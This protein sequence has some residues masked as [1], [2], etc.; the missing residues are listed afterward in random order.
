MNPIRPIIDNLEKT[1]VVRYNG[2]DIIGKIV[3][4]T[5]KKVGVSYPV[6]YIMTPHGSIIRCGTGLIRTINDEDIEKEKELVKKAIK[7]NEVAY[8]GM[9]EMLKLYHSDIDTK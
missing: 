1:V 7:S 8:K 3:R 9:S 6:A 5:G 2:E 4:L